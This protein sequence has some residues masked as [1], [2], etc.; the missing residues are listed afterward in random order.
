LKKTGVL[1]LKEDQLKIGLV[2]GFILPLLV[3]ALIYFLRFNYY[4]L[5]EFFATFLQ[6]SRLITF[7][8]AWCLLA[9]IG[10]FTLFINSNRYRTAKGVFIESLFYGLAFLL[11]KLLN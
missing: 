1:I 2:L 8:S 4:D 11:L 3:F 10:L 7:F 5:D 6:E 9:N